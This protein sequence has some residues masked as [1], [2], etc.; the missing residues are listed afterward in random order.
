MCTHIH[1]VPPYTS[2]R[3]I[4]SYSCNN[5][6]AHITG[7]YIQR[8]LSR[9]KRINQIPDPLSDIKM[10]RHLLQLHSRHTLY[11]FID[12]SEIIITLLT[13]TIGNEYSLNLLN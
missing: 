1:N 12:I 2:W 7:I 13:I 4:P 6:V 10:I 8:V 3:W 9:F 11:Q 5:N